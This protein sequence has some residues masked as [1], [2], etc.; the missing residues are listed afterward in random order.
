[1]RSASRNLR[2]ELKRLDASLKQLQ[3]PKE[4]KKE[5]NRKIC[6]KCKQDAGKNFFFVYKRDNT[7]K[8]KICKVCYDRTREK[9]ATRTFTPSEQF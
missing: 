7:L 6:M 3:S 9:P 4:T 8:G 5:I 1:M 2:Q